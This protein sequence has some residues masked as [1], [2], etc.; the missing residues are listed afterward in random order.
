MAKP[1]LMDALDNVESNYAD[2]VEI[3]NDMLHDLMS[4]VNN[5][6][7]SIGTNINSYSI[8]QLKEYLWTLQHHA[9]KLSEV[10]EKSVLK[11]DLAE[12]LRKEQY[13]NKFNEA[14]G[15]AAVKDNIALIE[16]SSQIVV[17]ALY[18]LIAS[19]LKT[20]VDQ[21]HRLVDALKSILMTRMQ[22]AKLSITNIE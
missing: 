14:Q 21:I 10:K 20:K 9:Y 2:I 15:S 5:L 19:S 18:N 16:S 4:P 12:A 3:A 8:D 11:A 17:E 13:A 6:I 7:N 22:E 1:N